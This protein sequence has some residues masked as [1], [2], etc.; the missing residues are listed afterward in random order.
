MTLDDF[1]QA[2]QR[3]LA[4]C[5]QEVKKMTL[6]L[7]EEVGRKHGGPGLA[8]VQQTL[9][10]TVTAALK[11]QE[12]ALWT[13]LKPALLQGGEAVRQKTDGL[14]ESFKQFIAM[15]VIEVFRVHVP[16]YSRWAGQRVLDYVLA[17][18]L[19]CL[20]VVLICVGA[21]LGLER[22]GFPLYATYLVTGGLALVAG[23]AFLKLRARH[24][25]GSK[26]QAPVQG[27][28]KADRLSP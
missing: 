12:S 1:E 17:G 16:D 10:A 20:A 13:E 5:L 15:T 19:F 25:G 4:P 8:H 3:Q 26:G 6:E 18:T 14:V 23:L 24:W 27:A 11:T 2:W 7:I 9:T 21:L 22:A 28:S